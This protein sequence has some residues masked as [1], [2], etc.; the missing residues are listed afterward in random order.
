ML[1]RQPTTRVLLF[2]GPLV[3]AALLAIALSSRL[4]VHPPSHPPSSPR[5]SVN[6][7]QRPPPLRLVAGGLL[8]APPKVPPASAEVPLTPPWPPELTLVSPDTAHSPGKI[9]GRS[10]ATPDVPP[11][12]PMSGPEIGGLRKAPA[13]GP[14][15]GLLPP[16]STQS[17]STVPSQ[18]RSASSPP[19]RPGVLAPLPTVPVLS[20]SLDAARMQQDRQTLEQLSVGKIFLHVPIAMRVGDQRSVTA[21]V[22]V[23]VPDDILRGYARIGNQTAEGSLRVSH[24]MIA[25]LNGAGFEI[26]RTTPEEQ[27]IAE[28]FPTVWAWEIEAKMAGAQELEAAIYVLPADG[29]DA[30]ERHWIASYVEQ[31]DISVRRGHGAS[32]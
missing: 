16:G 10:F 19:V 8:L 20:D 23:N 28:G 6:Q 3:M 29:S 7:T 5:V 12:A 1:A 15:Q 32:G 13:L 2:G 17:T 11:S 24:H 9:P 18:P 14:A 22:G 27:T 25:T 26:K 21:R 31:I 4:G 30:P